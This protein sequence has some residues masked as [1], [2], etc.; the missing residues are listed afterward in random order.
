MPPTDHIFF[1]FKGFVKKTFLI[2]KHSS[3]MRTI[4][5][6]S[7]LWGGGSAPGQYALGGLPLWESAPGRSALG[8]SSLWG[9]VVSQHALRQTLSPVDRMTDT[10]KNI[11]FATSLRTVIRKHSSMRMR[12]GRLQTVRVSVLPDLNTM[13]ALKFE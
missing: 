1:Y 6:S 7:R 12:T 9:W 8:G 3:R 10:C 4:R 5:N 13:G 11:T 2:R